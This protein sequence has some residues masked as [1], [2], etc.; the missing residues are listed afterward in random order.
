MIL[1][2]KRRYEG[3][4]LTEVLLVLVVAAGM[5]LLGMQQVSTYQ[6]DANVQQTKNDVNKLFS[7]MALYY[8]QN[9]NGMISSANGFVPGTLNPSSGNAPNLSVDI[10]NDLIDSGFLASNLSH[11]NPILDNNP[12]SS[13]PTYVVQF[14]HDQFSS[15]PRYQCTVGNGPGN[16]SG[17]ADV[18]MIDVWRAQVAVLLN[19]TPGN[20]GQ[21]YLS[22]LG[23]DCLSSYQNN[24]VLPCNQAS[25]D[26]NNQYVV[27]ERAPLLGGSGSMS[28]Y[29]GINPS[30]RQFD[31]MYTTYQINYLIST[32][33]STVPSSQAQYYLCSG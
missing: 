3:F 29:W 4:T 1:S 33:G 28:N 23:G 9:C 5:L 8:R 21:Q 2:S 27:W 20:I 17:G 16:C 24:I 7:A 26:N 13:Q 12:A 25:P 18:G 14:N 15:Q 31:Q 6:R 19:F 22:M 10:Q 11:I 32:G 30:V